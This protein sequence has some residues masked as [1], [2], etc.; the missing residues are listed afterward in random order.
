[1]AVEVMRNSA[2][3]VS[4]ISASGTSRTEILRVSS[5]TTAFIDNSYHHELFSSTEECVETSGDV[6]EEV[7]NNSKN[8]CRTLFRWHSRESAT[9]NCQ[10]FCASS[11]SR[12]Q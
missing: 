10:F 2:S 9:D 3:V 12:R 4:C 5:R 8:N 1:M 11:C 6:I 7:P